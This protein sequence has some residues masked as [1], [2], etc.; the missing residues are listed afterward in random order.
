[1]S[2]H[3]S[4]KTVQ[5]VIP[6]SAYYLGTMAG[7][8]ADCSVML[9][10]LRGYCLEGIWFGSGGVGDG[11]SLESPTFRQR[12]ELRNIEQ[13]I[14]GGPSLSALS[15]KLSSA[16]YSRR[17]AGDGGMSVGTMLCGFAPTSIPQIFY[18]DSQGS[19]EEGGCFAVGSGGE[20][21]LGVL[22]KFLRHDCSSTGAGRGA[23]PPGPP[24]LE[25]VGEAVKFGVE[26][27]RVAGSRDGYSG[28]YCNVYL[29]QPG[30]GWRKVWGGDLGKKGWGFEENT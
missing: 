28:G 13:G 25:S 22:D 10:C 5:K 20:Y 15:Q 21:A 2:S 16:L 26:A 7:G 19:I 12:T 18:V 27:I 1:M 17:D 30:L 11:T 8:A 29:I 23:I 6:L 4:S 3:I 24:V 14:G 9:R